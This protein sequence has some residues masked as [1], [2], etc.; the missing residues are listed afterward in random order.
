ME[1]TTQELVLRDLAV[2]RK[3]LNMEKNQ[4]L[5]Q[6]LD[7][8]LLDLVQDVVCWWWSC[9][10]RP[11]G[12]PRTAHVCPGRCVANFKPMWSSSNNMG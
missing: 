8:P 9:R 11:R 3:E 5:R 2:K 1:L 4:L 7:R 10:A 12:T 6:K